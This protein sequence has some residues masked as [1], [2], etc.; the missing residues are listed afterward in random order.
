VSRHLHPVLGRLVLGGAAVVL[1]A[2]CGGDGG[3]SAGEPATTQDAADGSAAES[4][5]SEFCTRA[6]GIDERVEAALTDLGD[7]A[8]LSD[9][10]RE[11]GTEL[12]SVEAPAAI[13][14]DWE[15]LAG[16]L[17]RLAGA[18]TD[19]DLTD[20]DSLTTLDELEGDL[21]TASGNVDAYLRDEC[22]IG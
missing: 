8:S 14:D 9:T 2:A 3:E 16:G 13:A 21:D 15:A 22:G 17:D 7:D 18:L 19:V 11:L 20:P 1:L 5:D 6:A 4:G 12:R 10:L